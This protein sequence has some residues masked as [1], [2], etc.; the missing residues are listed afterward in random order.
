MPDLAWNIATWDG[1][2]ATW[3]GHHDW[4]TGGEEWSE[5]WG[6]SEAQWFGSLYSRLHRFLP[7]KSILEIAPGFGRWTKFLIPNSSR[8]IGVDLSQQCV[9]ACRRTFFNV[10]HA[11]FIKNDGLFLVGIQ[12]NSCGLVFSFDSLPHADLEILQSYI[13]EIIRVLSSDGVA[14][15]HHSNLLAFNGSI[16]QPHARSLTV[17]ADNVAGAVELAGGRVVVLGDPSGAHPL[18]RSGGLFG[19]VGCK[20]RRR[21]VL[22]VAHQ[23]HRFVV[24]QRDVERAAG[25]GGLALQAHEQ[26]HRLA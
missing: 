3:D 18:A 7:T 20:L 9:D 1:H 23:V 25:R 26:V 6:G 15:I 24:P 22:E 4:K 5:R 8:Y 21:R 12:N 14:F 17:S 13:Y 16:G 11:A 2:H 10:G 19:H